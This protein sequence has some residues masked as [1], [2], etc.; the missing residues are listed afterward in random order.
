MKWIEF[1]KV[2]TPANPNQVLNRE[3]LGLARN[4]TNKPGLTDVAVSRHASI[5]G[6]FA[7]FLSWDTDELEISGSEIGLNV[8]QV[9][10]KHGLVNHSVWL[11]TE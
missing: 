11:S 4:L 9:L 3:L 10:R 1:I 5:P 8:G 7:M 2:Q 6:D